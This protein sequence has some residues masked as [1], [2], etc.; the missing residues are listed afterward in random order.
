MAVLVLQ[1]VHDTY[2]TPLSGAD[3]RNDSVRQALAQLGDLR[4]FA[5]SASTAKDRPSPETLKRL[6]R[7][8]LVVIEGVGL[9]DA[10]EACRVVWPGVAMVIDFHNI[11]SHLLQQN[12]RARLP[13][14]LRPLA[15]ALFRGRWRAAE[16]LDRRALELADRVWTCSDEDRRL[17]STLCGDHGGG[18][19]AI[20]VIPNI[21]PGWCEAGDVPVNRPF[22]APEILFIGHLGY[23]PNKRAARRLARRVLP[24]LRRRHPSARLTIAGRRPNARL[25][26]DLATCPNVTL[27]ADPA[28]L[29]DLYRQADLMIVPL[30]EGGG[31][32]IKVLEALALGCP[33]VASAKA[34]EG[35]GL[36]PDRHVLLAETA[37]EIAAAT[38]RLMQDPDLRAALIAQGR[39]FV[40]S[41][42][43]R[44]SLDG[45]VAADVAGLVHAGHRQ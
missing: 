43:G 8:D 36:V 16:A 18:R 40:M 4:Q 29:A 22:A 45:A 34:V 7:P 35:L 41:R 21:V 42:H 12:D 14:I 11:E 2:D 6:P 19:A 17:A 24:E 28:D 26:R 20:S 25:R 13:R 27:R 37:P 32:R 10:A 23:A 31:S 3:W 44:A 5:A 9:M 38:D 1:V 15:G 33:V 39:D 30:T